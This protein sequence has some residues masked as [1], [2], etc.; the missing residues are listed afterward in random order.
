MAR[1][2][3]IRSNVHRQREVAAQSLSP[4]INHPKCA[5]GKFTVFK[6]RFCGLD[7][8]RMHA[9]VAIHQHH[10]RAFCGDPRESLVSDLCRSCSCCSHYPRC[11]QFS[12]QELLNGFA[13]QAV[14]ADPEL[15]LTIGLLPE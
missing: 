14:E 11:I 1:K 9:I 13:G 12:S 10:A 2:H 8:G 7:P 6:T 3:L 5:P 15:E 4:L